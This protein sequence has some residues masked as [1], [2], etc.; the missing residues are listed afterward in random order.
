MLLSGRETLSKE[1][2]HNL[3]HSSKPSCDRSL[4]FH[5][6]P[7]RLNVALAF[8]SLVCEIILQM[9]P[10]CIPQDLYPFIRRKI[11]ERFTLFPG[12]LQRGRYCE[13]SRMR[14][15]R[16]IEKSPIM[17]LQP[18]RLCDKNVAQP[19]EKHCRGK[20]PLRSPVK[21]FCRENFF[22]GLFKTPF[23]PY[24]VRKEKVLCLRSSLFAFIRAIVF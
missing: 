6:L 2:L 4:F 11:F 14:Q 8:V 12:R 24:T 17:S 19:A 10:P 5:C 22:G 7:P 21:I 18:V 13:K 16:K 1:E 9:I 15:A 23:C 3:G 20:I